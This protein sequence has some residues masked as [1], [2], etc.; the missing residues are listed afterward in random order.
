M[1]LDAFFDRSRVI[2]LSV[3]EKQPALKEMVRK[4]EELGDIQ[5][6]DRY[7]AQV[8]HRES[9]ENTGIG[10]GLAIPHART[11]SVQHLS[12]VFAVAKEGFDY[13]SF[14]GQPVRFL[15]LSIFPTDTS[16][17][18]LYLVSMMA[19]IFSDDEKVAKL[20][21]LASADDV[22]DFL[23]VEADAYFE[24]ISEKKQK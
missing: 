3:T 6:A 16:T 12:C 14:D 11:D 22:Y 24:S 13:Q 20:N 5:H 9:L 2:E 10:K 4:L 1:K 7:Y 8:V 23:S 21:L 15:L 17:K 19:K 18:Y